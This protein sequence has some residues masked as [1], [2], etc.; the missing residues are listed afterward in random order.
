MASEFSSRFLLGRS[1]LRSSS[2][3][4]RIFA[5]PEKTEINNALRIISRM[6]WVLSVINFSAVTGG[7]WFAYS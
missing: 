6:N 7:E 3:S 1:I 4:G 2:L 5:D